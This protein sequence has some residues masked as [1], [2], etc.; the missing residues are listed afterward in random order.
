MEE[1]WHFISLKCLRYGLVDWMT[2]QLAAHNSKGID[3]NVSQTISGLSPH[4]LFQFDAFINYN[5]SEFWEK[6]S[7]SCRITIQVSKA[8]LSI[9]ALILSWAGSEQLEDWHWSP[10]HTLRNSG[11]PQPGPLQ[12]QGPCWSLVT[13]PGP[14]RGQLTDSQPPPPFRGACLAG[15]NK[16]TS[17]TWVPVFSLSL[18]SH[19]LTFPSVWALK[20]AFW[21]NA[22]ELSSPTPRLIWNAF[23]E[24]EKLEQSGYTILNWL[25]H[26][27]AGI[28]ELAF[29]CIRHETFVIWA[30]ATVTKA[31]AA[32]KPPQWLLFFGTLADWQRSPTEGLDSPIRMPLPLSLHKLKETHP[33]EVT[34]DSIRNGD[35]CFR[36]VPWNVIFGWSYALPL[37]M[38]VSFYQFLEFALSPIKEIST[39]ALICLQGNFSNSSL[40]LHCSNIITSF[41]KNPMEFNW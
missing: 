21:V 26:G 20:T 40:E 30:A 24:G 13:L 15:E 6:W 34:H 28:S 29:V 7:Q 14:C 33:P 19:W 2:F 16:H 25:G 35:T 4:N 11:P 8:L 9:P 31:A 22:G 10:D 17:H 39:M 3:S 5:M 18:F 32:E 41:S 23:R 37:T 1:S 27:V 38:R 12:S 36:Q